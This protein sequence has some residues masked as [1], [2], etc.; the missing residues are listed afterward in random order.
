LKDEN[1]STNKTLL[2]IPQ[3]TMEKNHK[4][5][6]QNLHSKLSLVYGL[7]VVYLGTI[8]PSLYMAMHERLNLEEFEIRISE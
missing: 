8:V 6:N 5:W 2:I 1:E 3:I 4:D 7:E